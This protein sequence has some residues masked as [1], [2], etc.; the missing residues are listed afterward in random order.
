[1]IS[2][3]ARGDANEAKGRMHVHDEMRTAAAKAEEQMAPVE[4]VCK[5]L[6][7]TLTVALMA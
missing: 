4:I 6:G 3:Q 7:V 5:G 1:M 2:E